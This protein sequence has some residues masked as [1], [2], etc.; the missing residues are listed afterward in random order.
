MQAQAITAQIRVDIAREILEVVQLH[1][2]MRNTPEKSSVA[3]SLDVNRLMGSLQV[4]KRIQRHLRRMH[5]S[6]QQ[7]PPLS[8]APRLGI[9]TSCHRKATSR[10]NGERFPWPGYGP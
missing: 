5:L 8:V 7:Y 6:A 2:S 1:L 10:G 3:Q 9:T 4:P